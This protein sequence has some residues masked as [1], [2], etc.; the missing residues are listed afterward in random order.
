MPRAKV[1]YVEI[2]ATEHGAPPRYDFGEDAKKRIDYAVNWIRGYQ[3]NLLRSAKKLREDGDE[4][5]ALVY[6]GWVP[7][8][9][10]VLV[11]LE[12]AK[13]LWPRGE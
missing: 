4:E 7:E 5:T 12:E 3:K 11:K 2:D 9:E 1:D 6:E 8:I 13:A 10:K